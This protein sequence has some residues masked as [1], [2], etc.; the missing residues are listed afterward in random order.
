MSSTPWRRSLPSGRQRFA[1][2]ACHARFLAVAALALVLMAAAWQTRAIATVEWVRAHSNGNPAGMVR[3]A[4]RTARRLRA[5]G[6]LHEHHGIDDPAG[7]G[8]R[9]ASPHTLFRPR[10]QD[11]GRM[12]QLRS[13]PEIDQRAHLLAL[14]LVVPAIV[15]AARRNRHSK[16]GDG[17]RHILRC[18]C[19]P[20]LRRGGR[21]RRQ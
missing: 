11:S 4:A 2:R 20:R 8:P 21:H 1:C 5:P 12:T 10:T 19:L 6:V 7:N 18:S 3:A 17:S 15:T 16:H 14:L 9:G 13:A